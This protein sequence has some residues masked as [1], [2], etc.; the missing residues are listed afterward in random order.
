[1]GNMLE[2]MHNVADRDMLPQK[3]RK[4]DD[5][6]P[7]DGRKAE[8]HGGGR[9]GVIGQYM[10]EKR[11]EGHRENLPNRAAV[12]LSSGLF[13]SSQTREALTDVF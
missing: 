6:R 9:G 2:R 1:M 10:R 4:I 13:V 12:D 11:E 8:F 7:A 5:G 3:R